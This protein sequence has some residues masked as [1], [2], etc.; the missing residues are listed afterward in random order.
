MKKFSMIL[1]TAIIAVCICASLASV[2]TAYAI[3]SF[4]SADDFDVYA[5]AG[6][7][8][9]SFFTADINTPCDE[10]PLDECFSVVPK[11]VL[12]ETTELIYSDG[13][14]YRTSYTATKSDDGF[15]IYL[16]YNETYTLVFT[17][18]G[19]RYTRT[20]D[21]SN[22]GFDFKA[23]KITSVGLISQDNTVTI[24]VTDNLTGNRHISA[25]SGVKSI[26]FYSDTRQVDEYTE[27]DG[28][29]SVNYVAR[30]VTHSN[31]RIFYMEVTDIAGNTTSETIYFFN[32]GSWTTEYTEK[33]SVIDGYLE[34]KKGDVGLSYDILET[35]E[36][37][38]LRYVNSVAESG[39]PTDIPEQLKTDWNTAV[40]VARAATLTSLN[41][42][43][44]SDLPDGLRL[45]YREGSAY[46]TDIRY[47]DVVS[48]NVEKI[49]YTTDEY[50]DT[51]EF[52]EISPSKTD[53]VVTYT[54]TVCR[55][56]REE[57]PDV[58]VIVYDDSREVWETT[59]IRTEGSSI[60]ICF[61]DNST[62]A[63][64]LKKAS[65]APLITVITL[66]AALLVALTAYTTISLVITRR[67]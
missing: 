25:K 14:D 17:V 2:D 64:Y 19:D 21:L 7:Q 60:R 54:L 22:R 45:Q 37:V 31:G 26:K 61:Q 35:L 44:E 8:N 28:R 51:A 52:T 24:K 34:W 40:S 47:G 65:S 38:R 1:M 66:W 32:S 59:S 49:F 33:L 10:M 29:L 48:V 53:G 15:L 9:A 12:A 30:G 50:Y 58:A 20:M 63:A 46:Y 56:G 67:K 55:N 13:D 16:R 39:D 4:Y 43:V 11:G 42:T 27:Y 5:P 18:G 6:R 41:R 36:D 62:V 3:A 57:S 23:P